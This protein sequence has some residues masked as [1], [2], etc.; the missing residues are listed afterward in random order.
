MAFVKCPYCGANTSDQAPNCV[1]CGKEIQSAKISST[2]DFNNLSIEQLNLSVDELLKSADEHIDKGNYFK[3]TDLLSKAVNLGSTE[4]MT[5]LGLAYYCGEYGLTP[6]IDKAVELLDKASDKGNGEASFTLGELCCWGG[7]MFE[8]SMNFL[9]KASQ[10]L[11]SDFNEEEAFNKI[12]RKFLEVADTMSA[13]S[14]DENVKKKAFYMYYMLADYG[15]A[16]AEYQTGLAYIEGAVVEK[17]DNIAFSWILKSAK[18]GYA[19]AENRVGRFYLNGWGTIKD[20]S[21]A[22]SWFEKSAENGYGMGYVNLGNMYADAKGVPQNLYKAQQC[23]E[24][25]IELGCGFAFYL[26]GDIYA[27][28]RTGITDLKKAFD[29]FKE[30]AD[31]YNDASCQNRLGNAYNLGRGVEV[32]KVLAFEYWKKSAS[33]DHFFGNY[34]VAIAYLYG[35][36]VEQN[37]INAQEYIGNCNRIKPNSKE[38]N[39]LISQFNNVKNNQQANTGAFNQNTQPAIQQNVIHCPTCNS[40]N[41]SKISGVGKAAKAA[42]FGVFSLGSINKIFKCNNCGYKW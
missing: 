31:R 29:L 35:T 37:L 30:G 40:T 2:E 8:E 5:K 10:Q 3:A 1:L 11:Y 19:P 7:K 25:A 27:Y 16:E 23:Y 41:V 4:A 21:L 33:Q 13:N 22:R 20:N 9:K 14:N 34:N 36:G 15:I 26:L 24:K 18:Q 6:N 17:N 32:D 42:M 12:V 39:D 28:G 38:V